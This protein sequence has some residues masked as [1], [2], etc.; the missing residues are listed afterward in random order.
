MENQILAG[1]RIVVTQAD[2][3]MGPV[4]TEAMR[5]AGAEVI[6]DTTPLAWFQGDRRTS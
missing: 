2:D 4:L 1:K 6:A 3:F 5:A